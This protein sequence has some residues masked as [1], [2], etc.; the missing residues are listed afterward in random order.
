[1]DRFRSR[2][3]MEVQS[4]CE[5]FGT[6]VPLFH[7]LLQSHQSGSVI[8]VSNK[9]DA[10]SISPSS[11]SQCDQPDKEVVVMRQTPTY[12]Y[13]GQVLCATPIAEENLVCA[14]VII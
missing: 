2:N 9:T 1:M 7:L 11:P 4:T 13:G 14:V 12:D 8:I 3:T 5:L 6:I 10:R